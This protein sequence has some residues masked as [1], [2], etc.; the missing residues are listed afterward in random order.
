MEHDPVDITMPLDP[1]E[2]AQQIAG[3]SRRTGAGTRVVD[4]GAGL[5]RVAIPLAEAGADVL[6]LDVD[7]DLL[8]AVAQA[9]ADTALPV[10]TRVGDMCD[11]GVALDHPAG[12]TQLALIL[13]NTLA[14]V[15]DVLLA[16]RLFE[17]VRATLAADGA[18]VIDHAHTVVWHEVA[19]GNWQGG[20]SEDGSMQ[21]VWGAGDA[22]IGLRTGDDVAPRR[23]LLTDADTPMRLW[24]HGA[25]RL[26]ARASGFSDPECV[27]GEH[28]V[29]FRPA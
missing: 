6:A 7:E 19:E 24:S 13:G 27:P 4:L 25:L 28:L 2:H 14:L 22:V 10:R 18:L 5:G 20:T 26:L 8:D 11:A 3:L 12:P 16:V 1:E 17:R 15:H 21:L 23:E 29:V 9:T